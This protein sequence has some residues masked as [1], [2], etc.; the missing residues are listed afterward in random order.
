MTCGAQIS[1][2]ELARR[3]GEMHFESTRWRN[4]GEA[5]RGGKGSC[6]GRDGCVQRERCC[7][8]MMAYSSP[9]AIKSGES[10]FTAYTP[11]RVCHITGGGGA[12]QETRRR[13][14]RLGPCRVPS[15]HRRTRPR[16]PLPRR[17]KTRFSAQFSVVDMEP[18][19]QQ[20]AQALERSKL[21]KHQPDNYKDQ[22]AE[23]TQPQMPGE[24]GVFR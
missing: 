10:V 17:G 19:P 21:P 13:Q 2:G 1:E 6:C 24:E 7:P 8:S 12:R 22:A 11:R 9:Y 20:C 16:E 14:V 5:V 23:Q 15:D 3:L 18:E 4:G